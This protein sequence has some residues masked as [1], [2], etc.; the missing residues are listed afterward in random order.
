LAKTSRQADR[1]TNSRSIWNST[2]FATTPETPTRRRARS[3]RAGSSS[4]A[5]AAECVLSA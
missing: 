3:N 5:S 4:S 2:T 1:S